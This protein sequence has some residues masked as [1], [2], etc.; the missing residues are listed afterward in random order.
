MHNNFYSGKKVFITG[1]A[2]FIGHHLLDKLIQLG[3]IVAIGDNLSIGKI[4]NVT[5][6]WK[7]NKLGFKKTGSGLKAENSHR[8]LLVDFQNLKDSIHAMKDSE[9]VFHLAATHGG[10]GFIDS[11]PA[12]CSENFAIN[13]NVAKAAHLIK[14]DRIQYASSACVYPS[15]LQ[16]TYNSD[17]LLTE[18]DAFKNG[19]GNADRE[20]GWGKLMGEMVLRAYHMQY[21]LKSSITR[22][23]TAYGPGQDD[24][25]ALIAL[26]KRAVRRED[27]YVVWGSGRQ[28][29]DFTYVEDIVRGTLMASAQI[30]NADAVNL[31]TGRR[32]KIS[33]VVEMIFDILKWHPKKIIFDKTK[34][35]GVKTRALN[36]AKA[37]KL[38]GWK[39]QYQLKKGLTKTIEWCLKTQK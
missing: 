22:Y 38:L 13:Q 8:F 10:R 14:V 29:R 37:K 21:G 20:Y 39:P 9:I 31:G 11:H 16:E 1:G 6:V 26:V 19:W 3:A 30:T 28:D 12:D 35:E 7:K 25:H 2:G 23:V 27:P 18:P 33:S 32:Y 34:P 5:G 36:I 24:S 15:D 17:Y 4:S